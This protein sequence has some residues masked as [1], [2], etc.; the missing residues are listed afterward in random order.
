MRERAAAEA[1]HPPGVTTIVAELNNKI[2]G[3]AT[4][5]RRSARVFQCCVYVDPQYRRQGLGRALMH[6]AA[7][8]A[9]ARNATIRISV[10]ENNLGGRAF[11]GRLSPTLAGARSAVRR[12]T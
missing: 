12:V 4:I 11:M 6:A 2:I 1:D 8:H 10:D 9:H 5:E 3:E 7:E